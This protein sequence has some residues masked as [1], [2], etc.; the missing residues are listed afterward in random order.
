MFKKTKENYPYKKDFAM[1]K[2]VGVPP[3]RA[4]RL[5]SKV[6]KAGL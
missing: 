4:L 2:H 1:L 6:R 5:I 3:S